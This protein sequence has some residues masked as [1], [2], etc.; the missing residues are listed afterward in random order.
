MYKISKVSITGF[1]QKFGVESTF[2][3]DVNIVIGK[4]G[5]GKT[6]FMNILH[7]VLAADIESLFENDFSS[8][9]IKLSDGKKEKTI[10]AEKHDSGEFPFP[11]VS[12]KISTRKF[13]LPIFGGG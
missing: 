11:I 9:V 4:N 12:Y 8:V 5:T 6:T 3:D 10:K 13:S 7:A 2:N 1:W